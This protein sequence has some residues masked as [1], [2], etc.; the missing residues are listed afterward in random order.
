V[1]YFI[2]PADLNWGPKYGYIW[3]GTNLINMIFVL[4]FLPETKDR[5][6][7]EV[8]EMFHNN[9]P[10]RQFRAYE[11][12]GVEQARGHGVEKLEPREVVQEME[13]N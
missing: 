4:I 12:V 6:L 1:P 3:F 5:M 10:A 13:D 2:N 7:E 9:V 11:C 8:D